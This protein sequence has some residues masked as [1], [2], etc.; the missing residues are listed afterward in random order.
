MQQQQ[1]IDHGTATNA[2]KLGG[3]DASNF[4][5]T[6]SILPNT[7]TSFADIGIAIGDSK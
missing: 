1:L 5:Q 3:V 6:G 7:L 4:I 2:E